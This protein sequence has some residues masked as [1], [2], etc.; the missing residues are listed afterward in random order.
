MIRPPKLPPI[1][2]LEYCRIERASRLLGCEVEDILHWG[3]ESKIRL[4]VMGESV[5]YNPDNIWLFDSRSLEAIEATN[6]G[7][8]GLAN[9]DK[10]IRCYVNQHASYLRGLGTNIRYPSPFG[11]I[12]SGDISLIGLWS[13][14]VSTI[15]TKYL[16]MSL[17]ADLN[18]TAAGEQDFTLVKNIELPSDIWLTKVDLQL[19]ERHIKSGTYLPSLNKQHELLPTDFSSNS[20]EIVAPNPVAERHAAS[21]EKVLAAA[22]YAKHKW[23]NECG[24]AAITWAEALSNHESTLFED[25]TA[26]LS[27]EIMAGIL[28]EAMGTGRPRKKK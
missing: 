3:A 12:M 11:T 23:P 4:Y 24:D 18:I 15:R 19:L 14:P 2:P 28:S 16:G 27:L 8:L 21:R 5:I 6:Q 25:G 1:L 10:P 13:L 9:V 20:D 26:P 7:Q 17:D 22:I